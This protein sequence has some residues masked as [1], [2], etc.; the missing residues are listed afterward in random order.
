MVSGSGRLHGPVAGFWRDGFVH[1]PSVFSADEVEQ[2]RDH[3]AELSQGNPLAGPWIAQETGAG[4]VGTSDLHRHSAA[5]ANAVTR[6]QSFAG[7]LLGCPVQ[8]A[9]AFGIAKP[10]QVGM[11]FPPHQDGAYYG[12]DSGRYVM[13][14][15]Y[16][17]PVTPNNG[18]IRFAPGTHRALIPHEPQERGKKSLAGK[19]SLADMVEPQA[20]PGDVV[21]SHLWTVHGSYPNTSDSI[22]RTARIGFRPL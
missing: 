22:R 21:W 12:G 19:F 6:L 1:V 8:V 15:V 20:H 16:L 18:S 5:W 7:D 9:E 17:D 13:A 4:F 10:P 3:L 2:L 14:T 11:T